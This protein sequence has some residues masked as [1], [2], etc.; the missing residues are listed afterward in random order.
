MSGN[1]LDRRAYAD[2]DVRDAKADDDR[3]EHH[4]V[5]ELVRH[6]SS[7]MCDLLDEV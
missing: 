5:L 4:Y 7:F 1:S 3:R 6:S 2:K